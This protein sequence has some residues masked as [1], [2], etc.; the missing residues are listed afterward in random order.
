M[1]LMMKFTRTSGKVLRIFDDLTAGIDAERRKMFGYPC[2]FIKG[3][4][5]TGT[6]GDSLFFRIRPEEQAAVKR[7]AAVRDFEPVKG[8]RMKEYVAVDGTAENTGLM[9]KLLKKSAEYAGSLPRKNK[10]R[11]K[12]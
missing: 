1:L 3:N 10:L 4:M 9:K 2:L 6:F 12:K 7:D 11:K 5:M 8:R